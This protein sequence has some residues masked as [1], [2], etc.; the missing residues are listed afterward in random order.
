MINGS[1]ELPIV[2]KP[3]SE[4]SYWGT[5]ALQGKQTS[6]SKFSNVII[7]GGS[8]YESANNKYSGMLSI[9]NTNDIWLE[10]IV[11]KTTIFLMMSFILS[12]AQML[13]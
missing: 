2:I 4:N 12:M 11:L 6:G 13:I 10:N 5:I 1:E 8:G 9:H 7:S 3:L